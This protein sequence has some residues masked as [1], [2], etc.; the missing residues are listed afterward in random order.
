[1]KMPSS[2]APTAQ[3]AHAPLILAKPCNILIIK[4]YLFALEFLLTS[5]GKN[6]SEAE[7]GLFPSVKFLLE[8]VD[9]HRKEG[10]E[11]EKRNLIRVRGKH[12]KENMGP[13]ELSNRK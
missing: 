3:P 13:G 7:L 2:T 11:E 8:S 6:S 1:M 9:L 5:N 10:S 4:P 12:R